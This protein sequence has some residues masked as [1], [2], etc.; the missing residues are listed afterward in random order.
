MQFN[1]LCK[2]RN[3]H[4]VLYHFM[5]ELPGKDFKKLD[6]WS[7]K[8]RSAVAFSSFCHATLDASI[9]WNFSAS[10]THKPRHISVEYWYCI[11]LF[12]QRK[13]LMSFFS[14]SSKILCFECTT[15]HHWGWKGLRNDKPFLQCV[16]RMS[17][18]NLRLHKSKIK[19]NINPRY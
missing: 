15:V 9:V 7:E 19:Q 4:N 8:P 6:A 14:L 3:I 17:L 12:I 18:R 2:T 13:P 10:F 1:R 11:V 5:S 16:T